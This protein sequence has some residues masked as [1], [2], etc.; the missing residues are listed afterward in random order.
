[1]MLF[2]KIIRIWEHPPGPIMTFYKIIR[3]AGNPL[4][5]DKSAVIRINL[6]N[7]LSPSLGA[8]ASGTLSDGDG[9]A[10]G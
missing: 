8:K 2:N 3:I 6:R 10:G 4:R 5:A 7:Y 1:M 9:A